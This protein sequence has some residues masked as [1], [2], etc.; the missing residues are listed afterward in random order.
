MRVIPKKTFKEKLGHLELRLAST[1][2][3]TYTATLLPLRG[4][5]WVHVECQSQSAKLP[6]IV[7]EVDGKPAILGHNWL[8]VVKLN[9]KE[10]LN[11]SSLDFVHEL[12]VRYKGVF[13]PGLGKIKEFKARLCVHS[14]AT[15]KFH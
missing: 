7:A 10:L 13:G 1:S 15:L 4:E 12:S 14:E 2:L 3:K 8:S 5:T 9:W 11:V 6:L